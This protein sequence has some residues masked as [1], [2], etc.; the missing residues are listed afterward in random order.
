MNLD[1]FIFVKYKVETPTKHGTIKVVTKFAWK[2]TLMYDGE[3]LW[4]ESY[5]EVQTYDRHSGWIQEE[6]I[7][8]NPP[9]R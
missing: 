7:R 5:Y 4:L 1:D 2:R 3:E 6:K 8:K 9:K